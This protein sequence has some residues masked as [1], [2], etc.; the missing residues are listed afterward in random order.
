MELIVIGVIA[1]V[2]SIIIGT[3]VATD[4]G[5]GAE[6]FV[7]T[8][9]LGCIGLIIVFTLP[10]RKTQTTDAKFQQQHN[11]LL[12][13]QQAQLLAMQQMQ[14]QSQTAPVAIPAPPQAEQKYRIAS[15]GMELGEMTVS[16]VKLLLK[17]GK[18]A[19]T[20]MYFDP[21]ANDWKPLG[22]EDSVATERKYR[23]MSN[24]TSLGEMPISTILRLTQSGKLTE[25]DCYY[26]PDTE[27]WKLL[28]ELTNA[29]RE[30]IASKA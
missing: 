6:G 20:D 26:D 21:G 16:T 7:L 25:H 1:Y 9:L 8:L 13:T 23:V 15:D 2:L 18:L 30:S 28:G 24:G 5:R 11:L 10:S 4:K 14:R 12:Q 29:Q 17:S 27:E 19:G 22:G 3:A